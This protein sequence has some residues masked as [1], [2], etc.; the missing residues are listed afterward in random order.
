[1]NLIV[2]EDLDKILDEYYSVHLNPE[3]NIT[4]SS[5]QDYI[6]KYIND[7][8]ITNNYE[9]RFFILKVLKKI[10]WFFR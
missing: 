6:K 8:D 4:K 10:K 5:L 3:H 7:N 2:M 1:M 9:F